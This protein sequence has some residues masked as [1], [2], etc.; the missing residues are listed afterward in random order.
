MKWGLVRMIYVHVIVRTDTVMGILLL[1]IWM[2]T[3]RLVYFCYMR[4][5]TRR[6][7]RSLDVACGSKKGDGVGVYVGVVRW[8]V[9]RR[10]VI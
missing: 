9:R 1:V 3:N 4:E 8:W 5:E 7:T 2:F 10:R 6:D